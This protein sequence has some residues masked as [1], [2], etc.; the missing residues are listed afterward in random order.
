MLPGKYSD[1][2][3]SGIVGE[4]LK[5]FTIYGLGVH[6]GLVTWTIYINCRSAFPWI[7]H[8]TFGFAG[9]IDFGEED[10]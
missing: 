4:D 10:L 7:H 1:H 3:T 8:M 6:L 9:P 2:R 5:V